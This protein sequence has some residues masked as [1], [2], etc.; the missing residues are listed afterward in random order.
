VASLLC[1]ANK[2]RDDV[3]SRLSHNLMAV[4]P[5]VGEGKC[6]PSPLAA[7]PYRGNKLGIALAIYTS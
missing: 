1:P 4:L 7:L 6:Q 5:R 3:E 2:S